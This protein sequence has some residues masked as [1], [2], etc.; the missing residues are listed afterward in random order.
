MRWYDR[1]YHYAEQAKSSLDQERNYVED[2][3]R[4]LDRAVFQRLQSFFSDQ[5]LHELREHSYAY[6]FR[7]EWHRGL[8]DYVEECHKPDFEFINREL[9]SLRVELLERIKDFLGNVG[10][11]TF[12]EDVDMEWAG[13][14]KE[15][16]RDS[17]RSKQ[18]HK[19]V[20]D[21]NDGATSICEAYANLVRVARTKVVK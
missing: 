11:Y 8:R 14:P 17:E 12:T 6:R 13:V 4:T 5:N 18:Y 19:V 9:E 10:T 21:L 7:A 16:E 1:L 2:T 15:W 20:K 3:H